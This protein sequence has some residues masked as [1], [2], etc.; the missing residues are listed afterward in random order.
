MQDVQSRRA[1]VTRYATDKEYKKK[2]DEER[3]KAKP[4]Q[5]DPGLRGI[6]IPLPPFGNS[7]MDGGESLLPHRYKQAVS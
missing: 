3:R 5:D 7:E 4:K 6:I 2:V 1:E